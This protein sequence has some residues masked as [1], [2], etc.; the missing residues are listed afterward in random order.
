MKKILL[1]FIITVCLISFSCNEKSE[2]PKTAEE[3]KLELAL[4]EEEN[5][6]QYIQTID[7]TMKENKIQTR[8]ATLFRSSKHKI[9]GSIIS[10]T[11]KNSATIAKFKDVVLTVS[12]M[13]QTGTVIEQK[14]YVIYEFYQPK[15]SKPFE[16]KVYEP[17]ATEKFNVE[18]KNAV[19]TK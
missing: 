2:R 8:N 11:I 14:D 1:P 18:V 12:F 4:Q 16:L 7:V 5:P 15:S 3:L 10:G 9:D 6:T 19:A 13:S 17:S